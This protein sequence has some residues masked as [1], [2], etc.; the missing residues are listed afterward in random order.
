MRSAAEPTLARIAMRKSVREYC[1]IER[2][3]LP[4]FYILWALLYILWALLYI[5][6]ILS[7]IFPA[8]SVLGKTRRIP[9]R[10]QFFGSYGD[11]H[12]L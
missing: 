6:E 12:D 5:L 10:G 7:S 9:L 4:F 1:K 11:T 8:E 2:A 3:L